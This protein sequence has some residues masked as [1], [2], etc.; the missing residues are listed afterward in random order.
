MYL[1]TEENAAGR[2]EKAISRF[3]VAT[4]L[5]DNGVILATFLCKSESG[6]H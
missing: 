1:F 3:L 6:P 2:Q 5:Y 4:S